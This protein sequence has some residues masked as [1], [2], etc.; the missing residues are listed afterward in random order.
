[1][2]SQFPGYKRKFLY[3]GAIEY[4]NSNFLKESCEV[5]DFQIVYTNVL[6]NDVW[7][8]DS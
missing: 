2:K 1:M 6:E 7:K 8:K 3:L 4:S 5:E